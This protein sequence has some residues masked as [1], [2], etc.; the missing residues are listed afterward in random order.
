[1]TNKLDR[2]HRDTRRY[3]IFVLDKLKPINWWF[4]CLALQTDCDI[5]IYIFFWSPVCSL[6]H[7]KGDQLDVLFVSA[8]YQVIGPLQA[9]SNLQSFSC[10]STPVG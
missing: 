3:S 1:M 8:S 6:E 4:S 5:Y 10:I 9:C 7:L 2:W